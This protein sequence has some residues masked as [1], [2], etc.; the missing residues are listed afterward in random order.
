MASV[1]ELKDLV[2]QSLE[3]KGVLAKLKVIFLCHNF[4]AQ[5][6]A[7]VFTVIEEQEKKGQ[8]YLANN[9]AKK[10]QDS[11]NGLYCH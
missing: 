11:P 7:S 2:S 9:T 3:A 5:L 8:V 6:R 4:Q 1:H 10:I